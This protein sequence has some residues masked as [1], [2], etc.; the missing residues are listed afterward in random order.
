MKAL[1]SI[2]I[3]LDSVK[4]GL[5]LWIDARRRESLFDAETDAEQHN[6]AQ[7]QLVEGCLYDFQISDPK[8]VLGDIGENIVQQH[9][10][11][12]N[13]GTIAPNIYVGT[14]SIP[15][16]EKET[17]QECTKI[18]IE[19]QSIK[20]GYRDD[21][22]DMLELIT[23]KC[24]DLLLQA[25]SP[26]SQHFEIDYARDS[27]T[28]YQKFAFIKSV[29]GTD[30][31]SE[32][33]HRIV[34]SPVTKWTE[35][36][37]EKDIRNARRFSNANIREILKGSKR[38]QLP[39]THYLK[40]YG[41]DTLPER[42]TT[43]RKTDSVDTPENRFIKHALENFLK[44][45]TDINNK[46]KEY[47]HKK[48][49]NESELMIRE[50]EGQLHHTVFKDI[51]RP[52]TLKLNSPVLQRKEGYREVLRVW[53]MFD[54]AA[55]LIWRG[56]DDIYSGGKKDI[57][58]LYEYWLFFKLLDL[59][60][61]IFE[62]EPKDIS[63]LIKVT[64]D[65][66]NLQIKQGKFTALNGVYD[67]GSRKLNIRFNYNRSFSGKKNYPDSG[68]WTT[69]L[70]PD[71]TLSFWPY[72]ISETEAEKQELIV[73]VHFDAKYKIANL[74]DFLE[75]KNENDLDEEKAENRMG[76]YKNADLLKMHAYKDAIR[77]TGG[78]YV[79]YPG[80]KSIN[81]KGFH[82]IIPG[83]GA[84]PVK[85]SKTE[86]GIG[87]LK[88]FILEII[89]HFINRA[90]QR[91][92]IAYRTFDIYKNPPES[93]NVMKEPLP[94]PY[95]TNRDLIP[96]DTFVLVGYYNSPEQYDWIQRT[97]L[98]NFRMGSG[99]GSLILDKETVSSKYLLLHTAGDTDSGDL[100]KIVSRGPKV[101]SKEDLIRKGYPAPSQDNYLI[102]QLE[103]LTDSEFENVS[104]NFKGLSNYSTGRASAFPF[105]ASLTELMKNKIR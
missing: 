105:T 74:T 59:F 32:A 31:F 5:R 89:D 25:N 21:Y 9:K 4:E 50:L 81:Q 17:Q 70:R 72:G 27:Q 40:S 64:P 1:Q 82:E 38:T 51:S 48:M 92:K 18:D 71:Y 16:L 83:L 11:T 42:I 19:V 10:R 24:T 100:W 96:D 35:T 90:S 29:I 60:Q 95:N 73:H 56:G 3:K 30:E 85:P 61:S 58:T 97:G 103:P 8:Y 66:L 69:T 78:A 63:E 55:K 36:T 102:I 7:Y 91:E 53:L 23:E 87:E 43:I 104:W 41:I 77:R 93:D 86:S 57:A 28:L 67:S 76:I 46:A 75:R 2:E 54:L 62:L 20:S 88:A 49:E 47:G 94:E 99:T 52:T 34:T 39:D 101:Y 6:E 14:L 37:E 79:L 45:C 13:L 33:V 22:R 98:Y 65:G 12:P 26:V 15:L 68:S 80:D 44:F 84:F